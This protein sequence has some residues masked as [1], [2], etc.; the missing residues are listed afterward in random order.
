VLVGHARFRLSC[1]WASCRFRFRFSYFKCRAHDRGLPLEQTFDG[2]AQV[3]FLQMPAINNLLRMRRYLR[4]RLSVRRP[5]VTANE[6]DTWMI[7]EPLLRCFGIAD[8]QEIDDL[9]ALKIHDDDAVA[10]AL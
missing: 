7:V 2:F 6:F 8:R 9:A 4:D 1:R 5:A 3:F 10:L